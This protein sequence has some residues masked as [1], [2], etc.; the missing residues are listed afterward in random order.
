V[1]GVDVV[2]DLIGGDTQQRSW[3]VLKKGGVLVSTVGVSSTQSLGGPGVRGETLL[4]H[5]DA[6][7][8]TRIA[9]LIDGGQLKPVINTA[10]PLTEAARA[11]ELSQ[12][13]HIHGKIV[14]KVSE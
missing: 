3:K 13:G 5:P 6:G 2:L 8:L 14:L 12:S 11:H 4:V 7:Q 1:T 10:L 9:E